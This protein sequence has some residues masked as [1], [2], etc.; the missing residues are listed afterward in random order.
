MVVVV[1]VVVVVLIVVPVVVVVLV[2][3][4]IWELI[5]SGDIWLIQSG[6][7]WTHKLQSRQRFVRP[8]SH[9]SGLKIG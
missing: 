5:Q 1:A 4:D 6:D 7:I 2:V 3:L 8:S 9:Q